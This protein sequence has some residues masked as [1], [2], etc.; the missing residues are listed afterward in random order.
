MSYTNLS[1]NP[2]YLWN[3]V[4][5]MLDKY[6]TFRWD[7]EDMT[8]YH[9]FII[10]ENKGSLKF[11]NGP[12]FSNS[13]TQPQFESASSRFTGV[14][15][16]IQQISFTIAVYATTEELYRK[17][18]YKL[19]PYTISNLSFGFEPKWRYVCKLSNISDSTRYIIG[20][21]TDDSGQTKE[22]YYTELKLTFDIVGDAVAQ[23]TEEIGYKLSSSN[24]SYTFTMNNNRIENKPISELDTPFLFTFGVKLIANTQNPILN[25]R[26]ERNSPATGENNTTSI[27]LF[28]I[29]LQNLTEGYTYYF[30][31]NSQTGDLCLI[32]GDQRKI[33]T[34][35]ST[36]K[37]GNRIVSLLETRNYLLEGT[38]NGGDLGQINSQ[39]KLIF[40]YSN[41]DVVVDAVNGCGINCYAR[42]N[43]I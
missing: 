3:Q 29:I 5:P 39:T 34:M 20:H 2:E 9:A 7:D 38:F 33:I 13:Y 40:T 28:N 24:N 10:N 36:F 17:L 19:H 8:L 25:L 41:C 16:K 15:F 14:T 1:N 27:Q 35:L 37:S 6:A 18:I 30:E 21:Y 4:S 22:L 26:V 23:S 43:L 32:D 31:Y 11:Y 42:R 12:S